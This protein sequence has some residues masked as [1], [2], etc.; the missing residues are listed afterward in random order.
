MS[1]QQ[2]PSISQTAIISASRSSHNQLQLREDAVATARSFLGTPYIL[3]GR[4]KGAGVDC[5]TLLA[6]YLIEI[7]K[8]TK[9][10]LEDIGLYTH[11]WFCHASSERYMLRL[12]R[13][14]KKTAESICM[15]RTLEDAKPGCLALFRVVGSK[16]FNHGGVV[17]NWP[18]MIHAANPVVKEV[19]VISHWL[20]AHREVV[21][22]DP[23]SN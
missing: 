14:A 8:C 16:V 17:T 9:E 19:N 12:M 11:D 1:A 7:G 5:G 22:F 3:R 4:V 6:Q 21:I 20:T 23:W 13:H 18:M 15:G 10:D 2:L